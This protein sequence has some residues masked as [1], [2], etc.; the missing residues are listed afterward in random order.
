MKKKTERVGSTDR[1]KKNPGVLRARL[2]GKNRR[3]R[4]KKKIRRRRRRKVVGLVVINSMSSGDRRD[5]EETE[6]GWARESGSRRGRV[7]SL[8]FTRSPRT[9]VRN[10]PVPLIRPRDGRQPVSAMPTALR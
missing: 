6:M 9:A 10:R 8:S 3:S 2:G 1:R 4:R 7:S 5:R